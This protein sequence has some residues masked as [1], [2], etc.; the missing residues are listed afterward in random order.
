MEINQ[1]SVRTPRI[2]FG[3]CGI[4]S[5][6]AG[7]AWADVD[8]LAPPAAGTSALKGS[9]VNL[10]QASE[11]AREQLGGEVIRAELTRFQG[12]RVYKVRLLEQGRVRDVLIDAAN[13]T[14]LQPE[15]PEQAE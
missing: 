4:C 15:Q 2:I 10:V 1:V 13:G 14:L 3:C 12:G 5:L 7:L 9:G 11:I 8:N 6:L